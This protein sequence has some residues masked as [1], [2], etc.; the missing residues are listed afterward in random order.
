VLKKGD[1]LPEAASVTTVS[2]DTSTPPVTKTTAV[3]TTEPVTP[4][5]TATCR[6]YSAAA[7]GLVDTPCE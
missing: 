6:K 7:D 3:A 5:T 1:R 4:V 2:N